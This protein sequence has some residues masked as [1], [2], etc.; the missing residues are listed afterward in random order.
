M[1]EAATGS[2]VAEHCGM[3]SRMVGALVGDRAGGDGGGRPIALPG[4][5]HPEVSRLSGELCHREVIAFEEVEGVYARGKRQ[6]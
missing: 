4:H 3:A 1:T 2:T 5:S 6:R